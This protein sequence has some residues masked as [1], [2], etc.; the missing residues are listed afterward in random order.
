MYR[1]LPDDE[2]V[3]AALTL[4]GRAPSVH[5][6]QPWRWRVTDHGLHLYLD[7]DRTLPATDP[8][9]RDILL[10]CGAALHHLTV[11]LTALGWSPVIHR[12]P[13]PDRPD[14]LAALNLVRHR[15]TDRDI[16][17]S[18][19]ITRRHTDRRRYTSWPIPPGYLSLFTERAA[20]LGAVVHHI[21]D[22]ARGQLGTAMRAAALAHAAD[23]PYAHELAVWSGR[24]GSADGV[25]ARN[26]PEATAGDL[27]P[28]RHFAGAELP[29]TATEPDHAEVLLTGTWADDRLARLRAGEAVSSV[30]LTATNIG[31]A[32]C[33]LT[34]PLEVAG[35]RDL[36]RRR[37]LGD[38]S[39]PQAFVRVGWA[40]TSA[41]EVPPTPRR[42]VRE[43]LLD[44]ESGAATERFRP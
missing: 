34:E 44:A 26:V 37:L 17:L 27:F 9:Q 2:T 38:G 16:E 20:A 41:G 42:A 33:L 36:I 11:A 39:Y 18:A 24:H 19:A 5:N 6:I 12:L 22:H 7:P 14:H 40:P 23:A 4:A 3:R 13:D 30:L 43:L 10:S 29:D 28:V 1:G 8:D 21:D 35:Q 15:P 32:T 25:P 31:L